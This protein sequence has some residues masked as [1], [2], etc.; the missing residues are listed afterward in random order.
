MASKTDTD[1]SGDLKE[2]KEVI[3][4]LDWEISDQSL[5]RLSSV[6]SP[7]KEK[8]S[9]RKPHLVCLKIIDNVGHYVK[10]AKHKAHPEAVKL[11]SSVFNSLEKIELDDSLT[12]KDRVELVRIELEKYNGLKEEITGKKMATG[13]AVVSDTPPQTPE[14][15]AVSAPIKKETEPE[16]SEE[17]EVVLT[18]VEDQSFPEAEQLLDDFFADEAGGEAEQAEPDGKTEGAESTGEEETVEFELGASEGDK[19]ISNIF[20]ATQAELEAQV[21]EKL[22]MPEEDIDAERE[23]QPPVSV[24]PSQELSADKFEDII[25]DFSR[26]VTAVII[27]ELKKAVR[28]ELVKFHEQGE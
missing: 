12:E 22:G 6:I 15:G 13:K 4:D 10:K 28:E 1:T 2:L 27:E 26:E 21:G 25:N 20:G 18:K 19:K 23:E 17:R 9:G 3:F 7:L 16:G 24:D 14:G 5:E 11:L 8:W